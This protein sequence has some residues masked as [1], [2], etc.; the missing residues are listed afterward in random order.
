MHVPAVKLGENAALGFALASDTKI[1]LSK[2]NVVS[3]RAFRN[4]RA[5][6]ISRLG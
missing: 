4:F 2:R 1:V 5:D 6:G 3:P